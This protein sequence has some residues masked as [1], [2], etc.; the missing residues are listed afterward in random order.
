MTS[1]RRRLLAMVLA[2]VAITWLVAVLLVYMQTRADVRSVF[3]TELA[4]TA[5]MLLALILDK[6]RYADGEAELRDEVESWIYLNQEVLAGEPGRDVAYQIW[7]SRDTL[8]TRSAIA[9][10][11]PMGGSTTGNADVDVS[12]ESWRV[13]SIAD[14]EGR[15]TVYTGEP[16][17]ARVA[18]TWAIAGKSLYPLV[19]FLP[20]LALLIWLAIGRAMKLVDAITSEVI[21]RDPADLERLDLQKV[22]REIQ[23]LAEAINGLLQRV[24]RMMHN[25]RRF[26]AD[27]SHELRTPLSGIKTQAQIVQR[28]RDVQVRKQAV[29]QVLLG[30]DR[31]TRLVEQLLILAR[32][33]PDGAPVEKEI[34]DIHKVAGEVVAEFAA[35]ALDRNIEIGLAGSE[36]SFVDGHDE[37]FHILIGNLVDNAIRYTPPGGAVAVNVARDQSMFILSVSDDGPGIPAPERERVFDRF[38]R[39]A[40]ASGAAGSGL[41]FSIVRR[42]TELHRARIKL[43]ESESGGLRVVMFFEPFELDAPT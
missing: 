13:S 40:N 5:R 21:R 7:L 39:G 36:R 20:L 22:P 16:I 14:D 10:V 28:S 37:L 33:E 31:S 1:L 34:V 25:E 18:M 3:D 26:T 11:F 42:I 6:Q 15:I 24:G 30:V 9:P 43:E 19:L 23:P 32:L 8:L 12:G 4:E 38:Y 29:A 17:A 35:Q 27:A 41:G 2:A